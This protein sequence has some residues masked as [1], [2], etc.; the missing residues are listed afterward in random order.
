MRIQPG[1]QNYGIINFIA[2]DDSHGFVTLFENILNIKIDDVFDKS[3]PSLVF[4]PSI[5][6]EYQRFQIVRIEVC[7]GATG[8]KETAEITQSTFF[9][10]KE[11][12]RFIPIDELFRDSIYKLEL[13]ERKNEF[14]EVKHGV[15]L[16]FQ[17]RYGNRSEQLELIRP[18][19]VRD[20]EAL[21]HILK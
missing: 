9:C 4:Y 19:K 7:K 6:Q 16:N 12:D 5:D 14:A 21:F 15:I 10:L 1:H 18:I 11:R 20:E 2:D 8:K 17:L 13:R 3:N